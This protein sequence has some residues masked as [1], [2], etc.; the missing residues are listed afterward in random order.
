M[1][2]KYGFITSDFGSD[3]LR[4]ETVDA[5]VDAYNKSMEKLL[6]IEA[7]RE[8]SNYCPDNNKIFSSYLTTFISLQIERLTDSTFNFS[9]SS[10]TLEYLFKK[11]IDSLMVSVSHFSS[12]KESLEYYY[13][14][15]KNKG[16]EIRDNGS[17]R[18]FLYITL[19]F[20]YMPAN[21]EICWCPI[22]EQKYRFKTMIKW[23]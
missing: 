6:S 10:D 18:S 23:K 12:D 9:L 22:L 17:D 21:Y 7:K 19:D 2:Y 20:K 1:Y 4:Y 3:D 11:D 5:F 8:I 15:I 14:D 16:V 13:K